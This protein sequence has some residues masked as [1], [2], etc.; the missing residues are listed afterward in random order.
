MVLIRYLCFYTRAFN[1]VFMF[2]CF[3]NKTCFIP[4]TV[5]DSF[6]FRLE[7]VFRTFLKSVIILLLP[8]AI[9]KDRGVAKLNINHF[10]DQWL[11]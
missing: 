1:F 8:V 3:F 10:Y 5:K 9:F 6:C 11:T 4:N 2:V 7:N